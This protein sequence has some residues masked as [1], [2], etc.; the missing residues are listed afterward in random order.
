MAISK[1]KFKLDKNKK[2]TESPNIGI[3]PKVLIGLG[4]FKRKLGLKTS[5]ESTPRDGEVEDD[6][7][8]KMRFSIIKCSENKSNSFL[9]PSYIYNSHEN[10]NLQIHSLLYVI[11]KY[12]I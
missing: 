7:N 1:L 3:N 2:M 6:P 8:N 11:T 9:S 4:R 5:L 12:I 10:C